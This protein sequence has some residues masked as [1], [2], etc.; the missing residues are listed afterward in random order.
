MIFNKIGLGINLLVG[1]R[2]FYS[3]IDMM[4]ENLLSSYNLLNFFELI[5]NFIDF[6]F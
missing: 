6:Y 1:L 2:K 3:L 4:Y 5:K